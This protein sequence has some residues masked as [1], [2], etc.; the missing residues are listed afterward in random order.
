MTLTLY[1]NPRSRSTIVRWY[2]EEKGLAYG[3]HPIDLATGEHLQPAYQNVHPFRKLPALEDDGFVVWESG[4]ILLYL[5]E[6][7]GEITDGQQRAITAQWV[8]F[9]NS[10][11]GNGLFLAHLREKEM[12]RLLGDL[13][14]WLD[15]HAFVMGDAFGVADVA[16]GAMLAYGPIMAGLNYEA[17]PAVQAYSQKLAERPA[18]QATLGSR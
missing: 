4:A 8:L 6:K 15:T 17:Y 18:F 14:T 5:A 7:S 11:L 13:N 12:P 9:A 1:S 16:V 3:L 10:T 2:L